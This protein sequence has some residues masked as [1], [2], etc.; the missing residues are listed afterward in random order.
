MDR[1][2]AKKTMAVLSGGYMD[3]RHDDSLGHYYSR[4]KIETPEWTTWA[5]NASSFR[6][7][8]HDYSF[9]ARN[10]KKR[11]KSGY[12]YAYRQA[13]GKTMKMYIGTTDALTQRKL[14]EIGRSLAAQITQHLRDTAMRL[15]DY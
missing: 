14:F 10:E 13:Q 2:R 9:T 4:I 11:G 3:V 8:W 15:S 7:D 1:R 12:W 6:Y 5:T